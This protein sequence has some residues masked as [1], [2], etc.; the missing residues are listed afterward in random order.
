MTVK[1]VH[2]LREADA[3]VYDRLISEQILDLVPVGA[4]RIYVGKANRR[5][6]MSQ[7]DINALL[8]KLA[9]AGR[10]VVRLKGGDP[11]VFGRGS[12]E[13]EY[14][15]RHGIPFEVVPGVTAASGCTAGLGIPLTH[16]GVASGVRFVTGHCREDIELDLNWPSLADPDTT[17]VV[18]MG[19]ANLPQISREL[20]AAGLSPDT[21]AAAIASGTMPE[22]T[23]CRGT[24]AS[25]PGQIVV[26]DLAPPVLLI[27]GRV[28]ALAEVLGHSRRQRDDGAIDDR[29]VSHG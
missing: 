27:I 22:E 6:T 8:V 5:H 7:D 16:R 29:Q 10:R 9:R 24:L 23:M 2:L 13:A 11:F 12:E 18:Y 20:I 28:V 19:L 17:L 3:V 25:L 26:A 4:M 21:P 14:L 1:A 15:A